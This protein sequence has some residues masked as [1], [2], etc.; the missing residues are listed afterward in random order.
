MAQDSF[1]QKK[2]SI[3]REISETTSDSPDASPKGTIDELCIPIIKLINSHHD[4]VTTSSCSGRASVFIE[5]SK[6]RKSNQETRTSQEQPKQTET[7]NNNQDIFDY[8][9]GAK[10]EG[11]HWLFVTHNEN[12]VDGWWKDKG[13]KFSKDVFQTKKV[14]DFDLSTRYIL[15]KYE[16]LILHVKCRN[17]EA[18]KLLFTT[19]MECGYRE[20]GI[21]ANNIVAIRTS[22][23]LDVPIGYLDESK[24]ELVSIVSED[25]LDLMT[26]MSLDR[27]KENSR[28]LNQLYESI[29]KNII[30]ANPIIKEKQVSE[31]RE[32]KRIRKMKEGIARRDEVRAMKEL[33]KSLEAAKLEESE[34]NLKTES[35]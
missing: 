14:S 34:A 25:Y 2:E 32:E 27:F 10:G 33:K 13:I 16:P 15:F 9:I 8:K 21:G 26:I 22:I 24:E 17:F 18:A 4:L 3:Q 30:K 29:D 12:E 11:G 5:G 19:A 23:R 6:L 28:K 20:S 35:A 7:S 31:T 1:D